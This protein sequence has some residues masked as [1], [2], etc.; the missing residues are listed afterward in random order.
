MEVPQSHKKRTRNYSKRILMKHQITVHLLDY[1]VDEKWQFPDSDKFGGSA[2]IHWVVHFEV[3]LFSDEDKEA[4][5]LSPWEKFK[6]QHPEWLNANHN[7]DGALGCN[8]GYV[9]C[10]QTYKE[11]PEADYMESISKA[12]VQD[13]YNEQHAIDHLRQQ[14]D[15][16]GSV[17]IK[18]LG[19]HLALFLEVDEWEYDQSNGR[20]T[21]GI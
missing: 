17:D 8:F 5:A 4:L 20:G 6:S 19:R 11:R 15:R 18:L 13:I 10:S 9:V 1:E 3:T 14:I 12:F 7:K 16:I 2:D 21:N